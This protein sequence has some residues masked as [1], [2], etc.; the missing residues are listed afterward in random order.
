MAEKKF[1]RGRSW[2]TSSLPGPP[3]HAP[4]QPRF[5]RSVTFHDAGP[6]AHFLALEALRRLHQISEQVDRISR[7][8]DGDY[9]ED[10]MLRLAATRMRDICVVLRAYFERDPAISIGLVL[11]ALAELRRR[12]PIEEILMPPNDPSY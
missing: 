3:F 12:P 11:R 2:A 1:T 5:K 9:K 10:E 8:V 6:Y 4:V 7:Q